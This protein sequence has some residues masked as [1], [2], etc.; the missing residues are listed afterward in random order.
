MKKKVLFISNV[1]AGLVSFRYELIKILAENYEVTIMASDNGRLDQLTNL[2]CTFISTEYDR[3]G[4]NPLNEINLIKLYRKLIK[5]ISP[6]IVFTYTIKPNIYAGMACAALNIPYVAN[7]TGLGAALEDVGLMQKITS[8]LYAIGL[9]KAQKVYFQNSANRDFM[10]NKGIVKKNYDLL[11]GSG[12]NLEKFKLLDYP[13]TDKVEFLFISRVMKEK[14]IDQFLNAAEII[15]RKYPN[16]RFH[17]CGNCEQN[18]E[19]RLKELTDRGVIVYHGRIDDV[20][21]MHRISSC[22]IHPTYYPEGMSNVLLESCA[23]GRPIITTA[24]PGCGEIVDD[25]INGF[26]VKE[27]D[28]E[29]LI[30]KIEQF[31]HLTYEERKQMG[32]EGRIKVEKEF[33]RH[34]VINKYLGEIK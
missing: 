31:M 9:K 2:G 26:I 15:S 12:V 32:I 17:V 10:L 34:I 22:T 3:H 23:S 25:G 18:Y 4:T 19:K 30:L 21:G 5:E 16:T 27:R 14:G 7:I 6:D 24:R 8:V 13:N 33:D 1:T 20:I 11:P 29:D 28:N